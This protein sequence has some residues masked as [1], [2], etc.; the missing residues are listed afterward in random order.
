MIYAFLSVQDH[1]ERQRLLSDGR[2]STL[3]FDPAA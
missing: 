2:S 1:V 3:P